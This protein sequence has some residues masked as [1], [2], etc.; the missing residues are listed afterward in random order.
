MEKISVLIVEDMS[1]IAEDIASRLR[2]NNIDVAGIFASAEEAIDSL[3]EKTPDL[4][5]M[6]IQL[7]GALDGISAAQIINKDNDI[8]V[9]YLTDHVDKVTLE[10]AK[11]TLPAQ[12]LSKPYN[13]GDLIRAIE[14]SIANW[15]ARMGGSTRNILRN[16]IFIKDDVSHVKLSYN[17]IIYLEADRAYCNI[18][19]EKKTYMQT[20]NMSHVFGQI[21]HKDFIRVHRSHVIN[22]NKIT[23][24]EGNIIKLGKHQV[25]MSRGMREDLIGK[26]KFLK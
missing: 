5:I 22:V 3:Q 4:I 25:E 23:E 9:I 15:Q 13:E 18:V 19:T 12:Y 6:D 17:D 20:S 26:L 16:H 24:I 1:L 2:K 8:P 7:A 21:K 14:I 11:K 10:R